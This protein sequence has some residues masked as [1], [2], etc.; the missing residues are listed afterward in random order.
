MPA[1]KANAPQLDA[2]LAPARSGPAAGREVLRHRPARATWPGELLDHCH[3]L[4]TLGPHLAAEEPFY[5]GDGLR[6]PSLISPLQLR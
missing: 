2:V 6:W 3:K 5:D 1:E 4:T